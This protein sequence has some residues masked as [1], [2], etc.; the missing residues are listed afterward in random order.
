MPK[1]LLLAQL[2]D[3]HIG[4]SWEGV[5][6]VP[7]VE[8]VVEAVRALP[9]KVDAVLVT[10]D[11]AGQ[12]RDEEYEVARSLLDRFDCPVHVLPVNHDDRAGLRRAFDLPGEGAEPVNYSVA[13][14]ELRL[15]AFDSS[16]PGQDPGAFSPEQLAWLEEELEREPRQPTLLAMHHSPLFTGIPGWDKVNLVRGEREKLAEVVS[17]HPQLRAIAGGHLHRVAAS[18]LAGCPVLSIP[19]TYVQSQPDFEPPDP[20]NEDVVFGGPPGFALHV[21]LDGELASQ[22]EMLGA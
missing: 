15:V 9:N 18:T 2:S 22:V 14:G 20:E 11:V 8:R 13:V 10:G 4:S 5:D 6:P 12:G 16:V 19:S 21:L 17:R 3:L 1:P 7:R